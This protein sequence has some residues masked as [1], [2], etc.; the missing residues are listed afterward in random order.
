M[1]GAIQHC[2]FNAETFLDMCTTIAFRPFYWLYPGTYQP[3]QATAILFADLLRNP[4]SAEAQHSRRLVER[5]F[6]PV[7]SDGVGWYAKTDSKRNL[8][9]GGKEVWEMLRRLSVF[10]LIDG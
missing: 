9:P 8:S 2:S 7:G 4:H 5:L 1:R 3:I 6:S 10:G